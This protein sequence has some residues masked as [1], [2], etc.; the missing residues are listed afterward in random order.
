MKT[1][2][3]NSIDLRYHLRCRTVTS[4][5]KLGVTH[6]WQNKRGRRQTCWKPDQFPDAIPRLITSWPVLIKRVL[7]FTTRMHSS[8]MHTGRSFTVC[9]GEGGLVPAG[10]GSGPGGF[11][12]HR[13]LLWEGVSQHALRQ[14]PPVNRMT[15]R[16]KNI[17]LA[18]TSLRP[19][20]IWNRTHLHNKSTEF[21]LF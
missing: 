6:S 17:T 1:F 9:R 5:F 4:T 19:A 20:K 15:Y 13:G 11:C 14:T 2:R 21:F 16:C 8:R 10:G 12:S 7:T 3:E 18:T